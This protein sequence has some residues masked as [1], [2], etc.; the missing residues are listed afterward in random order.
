MTLRRPL[1][2][3]VR[4]N[5]VTHI[6]GATEEFRRNA[7][8]L[9]DEIIGLL[10]E[11]DERNGI[12]FHLNLQSRLVGHI[13][14]RFAQWNIVQSHGD[15]RGRRARYGCHSRRCA[16]TPANG[17]PGSSGSTWPRRRTA[18]AGWRSSGAARRRDR[19]HWHRRRGNLAQ[20]HKPQHNVH[21]PLPLRA[22]VVLGCLFP[23]HIDCFSNGCIAKFYV[24]N[25]YAVQ[26]VRHLR[27][28]TQ[29]ASPRGSSHRAH[30]TVF[31][32][33]LLPG[34]FHLP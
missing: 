23:N 2:G 18:A 29:L 27:G 28:P 30:G 21:A 26:L 33:R 9:R 4:S 13:S 25:D 7:I 5:I 19:L 10:A 3:N 1:A 32:D 24:R 34:S 31:A 17:C 8:S 12:G 15:A 11:R 20:R 22:C 6:Q 14:Q 16:R